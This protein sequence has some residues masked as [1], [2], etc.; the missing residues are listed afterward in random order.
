[1]PATDQDRRKNRDEELTPG[2][3]P[4]SAY[5]PKPGHAS[6]RT[7]K[8]VTDPITGEPQGPPEPAASR[9]PDQLGGGSG[10]EH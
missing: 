4:R 3:P 7:R 2:R 9:R 10:E 8:T 5:E 6:T 1:M